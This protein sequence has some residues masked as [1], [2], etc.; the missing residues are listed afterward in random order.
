MR[1]MMI[2]PINYARSMLDG[3]H[4]LEIHDAYVK[5][6]RTKERLPLKRQPFFIGGIMEIS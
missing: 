1:K 6:S 2:L 4:A 5:E 3:E